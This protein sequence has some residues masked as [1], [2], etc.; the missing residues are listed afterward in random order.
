MSR[1]IRP[2]TPPTPPVP[3]GD[4]RLWWGIWLT[5]INVAL[6]LTVCA[7]LATIARGLH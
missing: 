4:R 6:A 2:P 7:A 5:L 3:R 1:L